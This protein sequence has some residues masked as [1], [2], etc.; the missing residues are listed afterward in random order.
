MGLVRGAVRTTALAAAV[1]WSC[2]R[3]THD[4]FGGLRS[5]PGVASSPFSLPALRFPRCVWR[6]V[7][8]GC[9]LPSLARTPFHAV[10]AFRGL[11]PVALLVFPACALCVCV[12]SRS[13]GAPPPRRKHLAR[14]PCLALV[15]PFHAVRAPPRV[16]PRSCVPLGLLGG[17]GGGPVPFPPYLGWGCA[18][19]GGL[20]LRVWGVPAPGGLGWGGGRPVRRFPRRC[21]RGG[22]WG[23][24]LPCLSLS[25][26]LPWAG[27]KAGVLGVALAMEGVAPIPLPFVLACCPRARSAGAL[28]CLRS[29]AC[30]LSIAVSAGAGGW[31]RGGGPCC[32]PPPGRRGAAGG[33]G[34][35]STLGRVGGRRPRGARAIGGSVVG[36]AGGGVA[37][38]F[39]TSPLRGGRPVAL[40]PVPPPSLAHPPEVYAF[41][42]GRG[43]APG[44]GF[45]LPPAGQPG[46]G[47]GGGVAGGSRGAGGR[48][49]SVRPS[50]FPGRATKRES[51]AALRSWGAWPSILP[52]FVVA[53]RPRAWSVCR[54]YELARAR[55]PVA[56]PVGVTRSRGGPGHGTL[57]WTRT[58]KQAGKALRSQ[59]HHYARVM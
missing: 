51:L 39:P 10:C 28:A 18:L 21:G 9:P 26:C 44:A 8:S 15:G 56:A 41:N 45:G 27:N 48:S 4:R 29:F 30:S 54:P 24:G 50:A 42:R 11:G 22:Q 16:L 58:S 7:P 20:G 32:G 6:A 38:W 31:G 23:G 55:L 19:P 47:G 2:V 59:G 17:G 49:A 46:G 14:P 52:R 43:A 3:G 25:L 37:P 13:H 34:V 12:R 53:C 35:P 57:P 40:R 33:G 5:V 1:P 36:L